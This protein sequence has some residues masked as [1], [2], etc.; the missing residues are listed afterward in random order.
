VQVVKILGS[1]AALMIGLSLAVPP[2]PITPV[3]LYVLHDSDKDVWCGYR[4]ATQWQAAIDQLE[5][6]EVASVEYK[7]QHPQIVKM[8][9]EDS[10]EAGDWAVYDTYK[11]NEAGR[12]I[13]LERITNFLPDNVKRTEKFELD[14]GNLLRTTISAQSLTSGRCVGRPHSVCSSDTSSLK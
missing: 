1:T 4:D 2:T 12:V 13:S 7:N 11:L 14:K 8:T 10:P 9:S 6:L 3:T 5:A